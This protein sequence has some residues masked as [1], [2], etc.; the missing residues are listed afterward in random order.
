MGVVRNC[1]KVIRFSTIVGA[2]LLFLRLVFRNSL[3]PLLQ[4]SVSYAS[5]TTLFAAKQLLAQFLA[6]IISYRAVQMLTSTN[7]F[8]MTL[9]L[10]ALSHWVASRIKRE[11]FF[12]F[13]DALHRRDIKYIAK[14]WVDL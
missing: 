9:G 2:A 5:P 4:E 7:F 11:F 10:A 8:Y 12:K 3:L 13:D 14:N 1:D 6:K